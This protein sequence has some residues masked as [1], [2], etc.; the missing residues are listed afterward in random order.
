[1]DMKTALWTVAIVVVGLIVY[2]Q[3]VT[4][5][6]PSSYEEFEQAG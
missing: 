4:R 1:M 6:M 5:F 2:N 3:V